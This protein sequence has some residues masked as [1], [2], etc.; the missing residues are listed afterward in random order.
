MLIYYLLI[1]CIICALQFSG[2]KDF[3]K[4]VE[5]QSKITGQKSRKRR[6]DKGWNESD[7]TASEEDTNAKNAKR[8][9]KR[10]AR[11]KPSNK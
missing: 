11:H 10:M 6:V 9:T 5:S 1:I 4:L 7:L 2:I 8:Q 3:M